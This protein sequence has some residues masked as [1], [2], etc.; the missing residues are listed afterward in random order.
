MKAPLL[1]LGG[2]VLLL[3]AGGSSTPGLLVLAD[4]PLGADAVAG[5]THPA[6][7]LFRVDALGWPIQGDSG[8]VALADHGDGFV[9]GTWQLDRWRGGGPSA[10]AGKEN[11]GQIETFA[12]L[13]RALRELRALRPDG[14]PMPIGHVS[15]EHGGFPDLVG[16][17]YSGHL[18]HQ[19]GL[20]VNV[21]LPPLAGVHERV[22][23]LPDEPVRWDREQM[24]ATLD[25]VLRHGAHALVTNREVVD[26]TLVRSDRTPSLAAFPAVGRPCPGG[27]QF[28]DPNGASLILFDEPGNHADHCNVAFSPGE[29]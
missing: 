16:N 29:P 25:V 5:V 26:R 27:V 2:L 11:W 10:D 13:A 24:L 12:C 20:H 28:V 7:P 6:K 4:E 9:Y 3:G 17:G 1:A 21:R 8:F 19:T 22:Q 18:S 14:A 23:A 15:G